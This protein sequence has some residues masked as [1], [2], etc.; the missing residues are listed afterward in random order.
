[1]KKT[2]IPLLMILSL[3][4]IVYFLLISREKKTYSPERVDTFMQIDSSA[5]NKIEF[6]ILQ[7][8]MVFDKKTGN[9]Y[10]SGPD[11]FKVDQRLVGQLLNM[12]ANLEVVDL[13]STNP[14]KQ[15]LFQVDT[16]TGTILNFM[17]GNDTLASLAVGKTSPDFM[18][19]YVRKS[20]SDKVWSAKGFL[21]RM[22]SRR[23][24]QWRDKSILELEPEKIVAV[25]F[26]KRKG[27]FRLIQ[28]DTLWRIA[29]SPYTKEYDAKQDE[30]RNFINRISNLRTDA[31]ALLSDLEGVDFKKPALTIK[32]TL[33]D[34]SEE[35]LTIVQKIEED[36]RYFLIKK[37]D[38]TFFILYQG[39]FDFLN[40]NIEDFK[41]EN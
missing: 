32:L 10:A 20:N 5:V 38:E 18:Y 15:I 19:T 28:A 22:V 33:D 30:T 4:V 21:S 1:M 16:L 8:K 11:S 35:I 14:Q 6:C 40:K 12:V 26:K 36:K 2:I 13:I 25:E 23:L 31:F 7:T 41:L 27:S 39:S 37:G 3:C 24:D 9:W 34:G 29:P 17:S